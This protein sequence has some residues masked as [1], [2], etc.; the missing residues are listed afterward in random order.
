MSARRLLTDK[1]SVDGRL[2]L[3]QVTEATG[4]PGWP[5]VNSERQL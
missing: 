3:M 2:A 5:I 4:V 1:F